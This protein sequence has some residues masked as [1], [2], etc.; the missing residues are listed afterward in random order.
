MSDTRSPLELIRWQVL[1]FTVDT[2]ESSWCYSTQRFAEKISIERYDKNST[3]ILYIFI[4]QT[5]NQ[6]QSYGSGPSWTAFLWICSHCGRSTTLQDP[7]L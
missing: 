7:R 3:R 6:L 4:R 2:F 5:G 1:S